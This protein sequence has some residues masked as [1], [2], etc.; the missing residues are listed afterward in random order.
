M[1]VQTIPKK[2]Q[3]KHSFNILHY[4]HAHICISS[5]RSI[6]GQ[7]MNGLKDYIRQ[8]HKWII[9]MSLGQLTVPKSTDTLCRWCKILYKY[10]VKAYLFVIGNKKKTMTIPC[11]VKL[12]KKY[13]AELKGGFRYWWVTSIWRGISA[14]DLNNSTIFHCVVELVCE[15][16]K[17]KDLG[18]DKRRCT[19][20]QNHTHLGNSFI[21][22]LIF[23]WLTIVIRD[24][25]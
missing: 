16:C 22:A 8:M 7:F 23:I 11:G 15:E 24:T 20:L 4:T 13:S 14:T 10:W 25:V 3:K 5:I 18:E 2:K 21:F 17:S 9:V 1:L 6:D 12:M 19:F